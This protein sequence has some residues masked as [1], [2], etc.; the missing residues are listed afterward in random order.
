VTEPSC[1]FLVG[2]LSI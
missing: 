2:E 1:P